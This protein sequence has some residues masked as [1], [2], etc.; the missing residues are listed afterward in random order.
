MPPDPEATARLKL[1]L[2][3]Q[4]LDAGQRQKA[5]WRLEDVI[6]DYPN[7]AAAKEARRLLEVIDTMQQDR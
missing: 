3:A 6:R 4:L 5:Q 1:R 7:T 2:A